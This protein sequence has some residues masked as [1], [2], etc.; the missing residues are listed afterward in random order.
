MSANRK[1]DPRAVICPCVMGAWRVLGEGWCF[2]GAPGTT[3]SVRGL[4]RPGRR[5]ST[6]PVFIIELGLYF[7]LGARLIIAYNAQ[8]ETRHHLTVAADSLSVGRDAIWASGRERGGGGGGP[9][10][11]WES[12]EQCV[13]RP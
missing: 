6:G 12:G 5:V 13:P 3:E 11:T 9:V 7:G 4:W 2:Q 10:C 8:G 1:V